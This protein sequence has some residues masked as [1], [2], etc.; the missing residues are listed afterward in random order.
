MATEQSKKLF[1]VPFR[2]LLRTGR[3]WNHLLRQPDPLRIHETEGSMDLSRWPRLI[4]LVRPPVAPC[5]APIGTMRSR[6]PPLGERFSVLR[7]TD[8]RCQRVLLLPARC[9]GQS[10]RFGIDSGFRG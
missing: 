3:H 7:A 6:T 8:N 9:T 2:P 10:N 4:I 5:R 1:L